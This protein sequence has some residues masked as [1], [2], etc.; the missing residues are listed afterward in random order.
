MITWVDRLYLGEGFE[1][2]RKLERTKR[3][4]N[5]SRFVLS[6]FV[7]T[8]PSNRDNLFDIL[9]TKE[10]LFPFLRRRNLTVYGM[11]KSREEAI[12]LLVR[13]VEDIYRE[14][15]ALKVEEFFGQT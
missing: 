5:R 13:M 2:K 6:A 1:K 15:G 9:D 12:Q 10:L 3:R 4:L 14:T 8:A 7:I 11:A